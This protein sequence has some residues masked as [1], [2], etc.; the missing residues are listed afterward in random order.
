MTPNTLCMNHFGWS[1]PLA[2]AAAG[3]TNRLT[4]LDWV[5]VASYGI[6]MLGIG[7]YFSLRTKNT[8][9]YLLGGRKMS[10]WGLGLSLFATM[11]SAISY[12]GFPGEMIQHGPTL[13][14]GK[15]LCY[16]FVALVVGWLFIPFLMRLK[17]TSAYA[18]LEERLGLAVRMLGSTMFLIA[19][20]MWMGMIIFATSDKVLVPLLGLSASATPYLCLIL[21]GITIIY[22]SMGGLRAVVL[23]DVIQ[24]GILFL[25]AFLTIGL[26]TYHM[27]GFSEWWP[28]SWPAEWPE[29]QWWD[30]SAENRRT[31][32]AACLAT[33]I[34]YVCTTGSDQMAIQRYQA[35]E[36]VRQARKMLCFSLTAS[37]TA[38]ALV[39][40]VGIALFAYCKTDPSFLGGTPL[41]GT[42]ADRIFP[43]FIAGA[44]PPGVTGLV[45]AGL[46]AAAMSSLSSGVNASCSVIVSDFIDRFRTEP[47]QETTHVFLAKI[48]SVFVGLTVVLL[49]FLID[50]LQGNI[51]ELAYKVCNLLTAPLFGLFFMAMFVRFATPI[52]TLCGA[53][54]GLATVILI[55][56]WQDLF[57]VRGIGFLWA[58]PLG[59]LIQV[60]LGAVVSLV[61]PSKPRDVVPG[62]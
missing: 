54:A 29:I 41:A 32:F 30:Y 9:D 37:A 6:G 24:S 28:Q 44:L 17:I 59:L 12:L 62:P 49:S 35:T 23:T 53:A 31:V 26:V 22:T 20:L 58:M 25:G 61:T 21:A 15:L 40:I 34:W 18:M 10:P 42:D 52:G 2:Q 1:V 50:N 46:L 13:I 43:M 7:V 19:R 27:G 38:T 60:S 3:V 14:I 36:S 48:I 16:P 57:G 45:M 55:S 39:S 33:F 56:F 51:T 11:L 8:E 47:M 4:T 5:I